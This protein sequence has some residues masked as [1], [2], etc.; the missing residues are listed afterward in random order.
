MRP[1]LKPIQIA[2]VAVFMGQVPSAGHADAD[3]TPLFEHKAWRVT[4][5]YTPDTGVQFCAADTYNDRHGDLLQIGLHQDG[6]VAMS[7]I[8]QRPLWNR[9]FN[10]DLL[11]DIDYDTWTLYSAKFDVI[12][13]FSRV[14]FQFEPGAELGTFITQLFDGSAIALKDSRGDRSL[15]TW[16][17]AGSAAALL[18]WSE[19]G[20]R[21]RTTRRGTVSSGYGKRPNTVNSGY[22]L[23]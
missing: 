11:L 18:K 23:N 6:S 14:R 20:D 10:D 3:I 5:Q 22:G 7:I 15:I 16:S 17:L 19:C 8:T 1:M 4:H 2:V 13:G 9:A 21:I 12:K